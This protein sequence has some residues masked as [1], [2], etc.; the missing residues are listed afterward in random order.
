MSYIV[1]RK[2]WFEETDPGGC[3]RYGGFADLAKM[4]DALEKKKCQ[5]RA[6]SSMRAYV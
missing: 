3:F 4:T 6:P 1:D 5:N 2:S